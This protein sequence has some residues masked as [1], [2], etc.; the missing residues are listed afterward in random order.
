MKTILLWKRFLIGCLFLALLTGCAS[1]ASETPTP[2]PAAIIGPTVTPLPSPEPTATIRPTIT[3]LPFIEGTKFPTGTFEQVG[4]HIAVEFREDGTGRWYSE[5]EGWTVNDTYGV[6]GNLYTEMTFS[7]PTGQKVPVIYRWTYDGEFL[8]F[9]LRGGDLRPHR[10]S[11][12]H[13]QTY[14]FVLEAEAL[15]QKNKVEFPTGRFI[16]EGGLRALDF[17]EDGT[18]RFFEDN[19]EQPA[20]SGKYVTNGNL[21]TEMT[22]DNPDNRRIPATYT[23]TYNGQELTFDLWGEDV[24]DHREGIY[25]HQTYTR[26]DE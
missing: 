6:N 22:D 15:S 7:D 11:S 10:R 5:R 20:G 17:D 19:L 1:A 9:Q 8:T 14:R 16:N 18:W 3:P 13:G 21:Y 25:N 26:V 4:G 12:I 23:W 24:N 2:E